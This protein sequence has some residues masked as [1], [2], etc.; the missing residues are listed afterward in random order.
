[1]V[2]AI[3]GVVSGEHMTEHEATFDTLEGALPAFS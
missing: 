3:V 1:M 2:E